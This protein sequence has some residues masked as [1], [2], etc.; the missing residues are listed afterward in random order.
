MITIT[1]CF[2]YPNSFVLCLYIIGPA[3]FDYNMRLILLSVIPLSGGHCISN[4]LLTSGIRYVYGCVKSD[5]QGR[6]TNRKTEEFVGNRLIVLEL[7]GM[8]V[9]CEDNEVISFLRLT[10]SPELR[11]TYKYTCCVVIQAP[12]VAFL[13]MNKISYLSYNHVFF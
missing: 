8:G 9:R 7:N 4:K 2:N 6:C 12:A 1:K 5:V 13:F 3:I 11:L 10:I